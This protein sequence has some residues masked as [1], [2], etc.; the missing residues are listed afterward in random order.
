ML[1]LGPW[2]GPGVE[3]NGAPSLPPLG[4]GLGPAVSPPNVPPQPF[5]GSASP[6]LETTGLGY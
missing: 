6:S 1:Q 2:S 3:L 5:R 4:A